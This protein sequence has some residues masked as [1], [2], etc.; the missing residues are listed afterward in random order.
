MSTSLNYRQVHLRND[1]VD[2]MN[3]QLC[4]P[5]LASRAFVDIYCTHS[6]QQFVSSPKPGDQGRKRE[7]KR[8]LAAM[9]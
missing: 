1:I 5:S 7:E 2:A 8:S 4:G 3:H 9:P 6:D